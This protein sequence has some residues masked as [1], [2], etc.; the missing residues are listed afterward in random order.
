[1]DENLAKYIYSLY[2]AA[3]EDASVNEVL[4]PAGL[5]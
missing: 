1:M 2:A 5:R 4:T 3:A